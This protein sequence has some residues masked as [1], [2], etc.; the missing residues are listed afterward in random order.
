MSLS[1]G[2]IPGQRGA[3]LR[4]EY[5]AALFDDVV[6]WWMSHSLDRECGGYYS[7]LERDGRPWATD[8]YMW[9]NGRQVWLLSHLYN[10]HQQ[11][12]EWLRAA[13]P[14]APGMLRP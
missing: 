5:R 2:K 9:M 10:A 7:L 6:P 3:K 14:G 12:P 13:R 1:G 4:E 11:N 8:K